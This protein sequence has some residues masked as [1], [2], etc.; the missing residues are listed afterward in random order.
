MDGQ[1]IDTI[2]VQSKLHSSAHVEDIE[3]SHTLTNLSQVLQDQEAIYIKNYNTHNLSTISMRGSSAAQTGIYWNNLSI[4]NNMLGLLDLSLI[5]G[6]F[7]EKTTV[8]YGSESSVFGSGNIGGG[9]YLSTGLPKEKFSLSTRIGSFNNYDHTAKVR[10]GTNIQSSIKFNVQHVENTYPYTTDGGEIRQLENGEG[11]QYHGMINSQYTK[12]KNVFRLQYWGSYANRNIP[13]TTRQIAGNDA[14]IDLNQRFHFNAKRIIK[15]GTIDWNSGYFINNNQFY[16]VQLVNR[17]LIHSIENRIVYKQIFSSLSFTMGTD[18]SFHVAQSNNYIGRPRQFRM[19]LFG[20]AKWSTGSFIFDTRLRQEFIDTQFVPIIPEFS[21]S[22]KRKKCSAQLKGNRVYRNPT[23]NDLY[24]TPG[25]NENL[26]PEIG[27]ASEGSITYTVQKKGFQSES[28]ISIY[29]RTIDNWILWT[30][31]EDQWFVRATNIDQ[32]W[33]RGI[34]CKHATTIQLHTNTSIFY[35][36]HYALNK[37]TYQQDLDFPS[38][39]KGDQLFYTPVH[40]FNQTLKL[41]Y[42]NTSFTYSHQ[43]FSQAI[44]INATLP[45]YALANVEAQQDIKIK[46]QDIQLAFSIRN[47]LNTSYQVIEFRPMPGRHYQLTLGYKLN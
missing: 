33:S 14:T 43:Y 39:K 34:E 36:I 1:A 47:I 25:G 5:P 18:Q 37:S 10:F 26:K 11:Q 19:A 29:N 9:I 46:K 40:Q 27:W 8:V 41:G 13:Y 12:G 16:Q 45:A 15:N 21:I 24:W 32:V 3:P 4:T 44:G 28:G 22:F 30:L 7:I 31:G 20:N 17:N 38:V 35:K 42:K 2:Y 23:L 6:S